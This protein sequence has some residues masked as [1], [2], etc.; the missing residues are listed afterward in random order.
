MCNPPFFSS[1]HE[2]NQNPHT[3]CGG[4]PEEMVYP[5]GEL[6]FVQSI[7]AD[8]CKLKRGIHWYTTML[9]KKASLKQLRKQLHGLGV[10][11]LRTT[12][13]AQGRTSRW[14]IAWSFAADSNIAHQPLQRG[15]PASKNGTQQGTT[16][17]SL[18]S[19]LISHGAQVAGLGRGQLNSSSSPATAK[20]GSHGDP[21]QQHHVPVTQAKHSNVRPVRSLSFG[22]VALPAEGHKVLQA[23]AMLLSRKHCVCQVDAKQWSI[24]A[25]IP[26]TEHSTFTDNLVDD[27]GCS[28]EEQPGLHQQQH[29]ADPSS[30]KKR[31]PS[32]LISDRQLTKR[33]HVVPAAHTISSTNRDKCNGAPAGAGT[34]NASPIDTVCDLSGAD[35]NQVTAQLPRQPEAHAGQPAE[36]IS[37]GNTAAAAEQ[38]GK[39][40]VPQMMLQAQI[41]VYQQQHGVMTI[42]ASIANSSS[43]TL[44]TC[45]AHVMQ[46]VKEDLSVLFKLDS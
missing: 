23:V 1:V 2:A 11:A 36:H 18:G 30:S 14:A 38:A 44:A 5:G 21:R 6:A 34:A 24:T 3:A 7:I 12:E 26:V 13:L 28:A 9:G 22:V 29:A 42:K 17:L 16:G 32:D 37:S 43:N 15:I 8:S 19:T 4:T 46:Q 31:G 35:S 41:A 10:K 33:A 45:F 25:Q 40:Q 39:Q 27:I 20:A